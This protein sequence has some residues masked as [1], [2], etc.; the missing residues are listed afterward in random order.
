MPLWFWEGWAQRSQCWLLCRWT[1]PLWCW[2]LNLCFSATLLGLEASPR[3]LT[4][5]PMKRVSAYPHAYASWEM[6]LALRLKYRQELCVFFWGGEAKLPNFTFCCLQ[7]SYLVWAILPQWGS[8]PARSY[9]MRLLQHPRSQVKCQVQEISVPHLEIQWLEMSLSS[10]SAVPDVMGSWSG[11][12]LLGRDYTLSTFYNS[13]HISFPED[14]T[15]KSKCFFF[16][17]AH[18]LLPIKCICVISVFLSAEK[19]DFIMWHSPID[20]ILIVTILSQ[21]QEVYSLGK[22]NAT[23]CFNTLEQG[24]ILLWSVLFLKYEPMLW[25]ANSQKEYKENTKFSMLQEIWRENS[26]QCAQESLWLMCCG[27]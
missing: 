16:T 11:S 4:S 13:F 20:T 14:E 17:G 6:N 10:A 8:K 5:F 7:E 23:K 3:P 15:M 25:L 27:E 26:V 22:W 2:P 18:W 19:Q 24:W 1:L 21:L 9:M 12:R